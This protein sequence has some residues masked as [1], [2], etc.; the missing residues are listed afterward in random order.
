MRMNILRFCES[1]GL[2][3]EIFWVFF[4]I[5]MIGKL[6]IE[7]EDDVKMGYWLGFSRKMMKERYEALTK[8]VKIDLA[9]RD[10]VLLNMLIDE[11]L[12]FY[13]WGRREKSDSFPRQNSVSP[14]PVFPSLPSAILSSAF[15]LLQLGY[16]RKKRRGVFLIQLLLLLL[17]LMR[18][19]TIF[20]VLIFFF[21]FFS[22]FVWSFLWRYEYDWWRWR[23]GRW[24]RWRKNDKKLFVGGTS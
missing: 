8:K 21:G 16:E 2:N 18:R 15:L 11:F 7:R 20:W 24:R 5:F 6:W 9:D 12:C 13:V 10:N 17:F 19:K 3:R 23:R 1:K 4:L 14:P 22:G